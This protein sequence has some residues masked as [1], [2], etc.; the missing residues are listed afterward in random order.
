MPPF[1]I[2][3]IFF[4]LLKHIFTGLVFSE[5]LLSGQEPSV[6]DVNDEEP[7]FPALPILNLRPPYKVSV[8][9]LVSDSLLEKWLI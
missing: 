6:K 9:F 8:F 1:S 3:M 4:F 2:N 7:R 5:Y